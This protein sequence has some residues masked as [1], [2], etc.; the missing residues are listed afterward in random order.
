MNDISTTSLFSGC[1]RASASAP[2]TEHVV[3]AHLLRRT[4]TTTLEVLSKPLIVT[5]LARARL[6]SMAD[7]MAMS[8][9]GKDNTQP[10]RRR[11]LRLS[12]SS[13]AESYN[14]K[15]DESDFGN[16]IAANVPA[17]DQP[18]RIGETQPASA[19]ANN[20]LILV[21]INSAREDTTRVHQDATGEELARPTGHRRG[22]QFSDLLPPD[23]V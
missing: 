16:A 12:T 2:Q 9:R 14:D 13:W 11:V 23:W 5:K 7:R 20:T 4:F 6:P 18:G 21:P 8:L 3:F 1:I 19:R 15:A 17:S 22:L 10:S